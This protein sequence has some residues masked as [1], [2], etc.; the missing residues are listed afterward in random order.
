MPRAHAGEGTGDRAVAETLFDEGRKLLEEGKLDEACAKLE[1]SNRMDPAVGTL[2]NLGDC[3]ER[4]GRL[5]S[6]WSNFRAAM[7]LA[8]TRN[9]TARADFARKRSEA[10]QPRLSTLTL[11]VVS[12]APGLRV[13]RDGVAVDDAAWGTALPIDAGAHVIEAQAPGKKTWTTKIVVAEGSPSS[14]VVKIE[15]LG[16]DSS[17]PVVG[18]NQPVPAASGTGS[19]PV[20]T[21]GYVGAGLG[22]IAIGAGIYFAI[23]ARSVWN[24]AIPHCN[25][26]NRCDDTGFALNADARR[27]GNLATVTLTI[28]VVLAAAGTLAILLGPSRSPSPSATPAPAARTGSNGFVLHHD[29]ARILF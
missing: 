29:G 14:T 22:A 21:L 15:P 6:A 8:L 5:A 17:T 26:S 9:D 3:N 18:E 4:R 19:S 11:S 28:G 7:S 12:P 25:T 27:N 2:L 16:A 1:A 23:H 20:R 10:V 24:E 13:K